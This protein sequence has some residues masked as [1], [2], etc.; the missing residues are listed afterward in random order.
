MI[1]L[2]QYPGSW[3]LPSSSPFCI[4]VETY[5]RMAGI[6]YT[7]VWENNPG[8]GPKGKMPFIQDGEKTISDSS[9]I[10]EYLQQNYTPNLDANMSAEQQAVMLAFQRLIEESLYWVLLYSRWGDENGWREIKKEITPLLP[11]VIGKGIIHIIRKRLL[12][13]AHFQGMGR[14]S[15]DEI[16]HIGNKNLRSIIEFLG[17]KTYFFGE[18]PRSIDCTL[19]GF[20]I[21]ILWSPVP[22]PLPEY[23]K[24]FSCLEDYCIRIRDT[25]WQS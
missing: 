22:G 8:R 4:K 10:M 14:H 9:F 20:F 23:A 6:A 2:H 13:Q 1:A 3:G 5:L 24:K 15:R 25:Y 12:R 11:P 19:Y 18:K 16:Y 17:N 7:N 21:T